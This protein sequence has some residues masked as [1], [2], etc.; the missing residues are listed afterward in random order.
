MV[1]MSIYSFFL[2]LTIFLGVISGVF[3]VISSIIILISYN[4]TIHIFFLERLS[5]LILLSIFTALILVIL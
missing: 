2:L 3:G 1:K 4:K 5:G